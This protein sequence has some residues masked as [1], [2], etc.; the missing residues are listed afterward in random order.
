MG[1]DG[2]FYGTTYGSSDPYGGLNLWG[3]VFEVTSNGIFT[4]LASFVGTN[5]ENSKASLTL[6][7]DGNF[8]GTTS[9]G[10]AD[11]IGEIYRLDLPP[12]IIQQPASLGATEGGSVTLSVTLFGTA[13]Y[14]FQWLSNNIPIPGAT[15]I[16]L[17]IPDFGAGD[18]ANYSAIVSNAW[19][20]VTS[21]VA[22]LTVAGGPLISGITVS[23]N[24]DVTLNCQTLTNVTSRLWATTN[25]AGQTDWT[26]IFTNA[27]TSPGAWQFTDTDRMYQQKYYRL[28]TP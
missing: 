20:S 13:P 8:Y 5:G 11:E 14:S 3:T 28:S 12:E 19:G 24:G 7:P 1:P 6:G 17:T 15:N 21:A 27:V 10:G 9:Y 4:T 16:A 18:A 26:P 25:L 23:A 22:S 2:N